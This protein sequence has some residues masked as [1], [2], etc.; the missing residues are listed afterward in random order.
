MQEEGDAT[1]KKIL[2]TGANSYIGTSFEKWMQKW[3]KD[4]SIDTID[5]KD[6]SWERKDFSKYDV[7][8]HVAGIAHVSTDPNMEDLYYKVNRDLTIETAMK[9]KADGA[10]Q[11]VFMSSI[12]V[13]GDSSHIN[14]KRVIDKNTVP[15]PSN[16]YGKSKLEAE[17]GILPLQDNS[18]NV[19]VIRPPMIFG[20][21]SK[22]NYPKLSRIA[23]KLPIFPDIKNERSMLHI[24]NLCEFIR[25]MIVNEE[26]DVF[27]PQNRE[28]VGTSQLVKLISEAHGK[29][30]RLTKV[31]NG[32]L[33]LMG[34][35]T[36][37]VNKAFGNLVYEKS[38]SEYKEDYRVRD[39]EESVR[40]T[41]GRD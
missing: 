37:A 40:V 29:N 38:M 2:I 1:L 33:R 26:S 23:Q 30:I 24:D 19:V 41:E 10:R 16:F 15:E 11:F 3:T 8:F 9:A 6:G 21:G 5:M 25:L 34:D 7:V 12:I 14:H 28:Y 18:F 36:G 22:G 20:K 27:Y 13:Y 35:F 17:E 31:F 32:A 39:L 4:Y